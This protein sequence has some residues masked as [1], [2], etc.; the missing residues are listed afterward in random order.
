M[1]N[2]C[3]NWI[4]IRGN[5]VA[6]QRLWARLTDPVKIL[7]EG[8]VALLSFTQPP[9]EFGEEFKSDLEP[10]YY[11]IARTTSK[12]LNYTELN[13]REMLDLF[14]VKWDFSCDN[15]K[16]KD[17]RL[18]GYF[19]T[20]WSSPEQ[21]FIDL[22]RDY[23]VEG[24]LKFGEGGNDFGG[25][26]EIKEDEA[27]YYH[28]DYWSWDSLFDEP[29]GALERLLDLEPENEEYIQS[30]K[31]EAEAWPKSWEEYKER[32][33]RGSAQIRPILCHK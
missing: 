10:G 26:L 24:E 21:W 30:I 28:S 19:T 1:P 8:T 23:R 6:V 18:T 17:G 3:E 33:Y 2:W 9:W 11:V 31:E 16:L 27:R 15:L 4:D 22:C 12:T 7:R 13:I 25:I 14:G 29:G 5:T 32:F 20:A